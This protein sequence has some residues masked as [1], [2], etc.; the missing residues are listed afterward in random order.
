MNLT[1]E[2]TAAAMAVE[3]EII[4][5]ACPGSG[6]TTTLVNRIVLRGDY[7]KVIV[8]TFTNKAAAH[9]RHKLAERGVIPHYV[10]TLHSFC[11]R[12]LRDTMP[13]LVVLDDDESTALMKSVLQS[14]RSKASLKALKARVAGGPPD[15]KVDPAFAAYMKALSEGNAADYDT[16]LARGRAAAGRYGNGWLL[17]VD[18]YQDSGPIDDQIYDALPCV[19]RFFVGDENQSIY[20]WRGARVEN[21]RQRVGHRMELT[22]N[23]R[24]GAA[25]INAAEAL[26]NA[27][28]V[29]KPG[30][31]PRDGA[32]TGTAEIMSFRS[33]AEEMAAMIS[34]IRQDPGSWAV[35]TRYNAHRERIDQ[36]LRAAGI[37]M[38][39]RPAPPDPTHR[40]AVA[41]LSLMIDPENR[42]SKGAWF[43]ATRPADVAQRLI[44]AGAPTGVKLPVTANWEEL[45]PALRAAGVGQG[46]ILRV[47][48]A[49]SASDRTPADV[50]AQLRPEE[51]ADPL[52]GTCTVSTIHGAKGLEFDRV[53]IPGLEG[54]PA[55]DRLDE[56]RRLLFVAIT[57]A[58]VDVRFS[59]CDTRPN[60]YTGRTEAT[61]PSPFLK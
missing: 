6:K 45:A 19:A 33:E 7:S 15:V 43:R 47:F 10:G 59:R 38:P 60:S 11:L 61:K 39:A 46:M 54:E 8:I 31:R 22:Q 40:L 36:A 5:N 28:G 21:I 23:F 34:E 13:R 12:M 30:M 50:L 4:L 24:S 14:T 42:L 57:R 44:E 9:V 55:P 20:G 18:E 58:K 16:L 37:P 17:Y 27:P 48:S 53:W 3:S 49:W 52:A 32:P 1:P 29:R 35:L 56:E 26:M 25:V 51:T 41:F 2:Q